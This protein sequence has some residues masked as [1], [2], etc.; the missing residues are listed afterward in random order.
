[1]LQFKEKSI[2]LKLIHKQKNNM[3]SK[4]KHHILSMMF[5]SYREETCRKIMQRFNF[6]IFQMIN[7]LTKTYKIKKERAEEIVKLLV[8]GK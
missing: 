5:H 2:F 7:I 3:L 1:M 6:F 4:L 8:S